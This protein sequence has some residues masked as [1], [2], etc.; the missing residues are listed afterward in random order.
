MKN[1]KLV[2]III[3]FSAIFLFIAVGIRFFVVNKS[4]KNIPQ[5]DI[6]TQQANTTNGEVDGQKAL[7]LLPRE[8][9][10]FDVQKNG[11]SQDKSFY[12]VNVYIS[13]DAQSKLKE[14]G[15]SEKDW[16]NYTGCW[17]VNLRNG[18]AYR[19]ATAGYQ[20]SNFYQWVGNDEIELI[21]DGKLTA[22]TYNALSK[23]VVSTRKFNLDVSADTSNWKTYRSEEFGFEMK[24]PSKLTVKENRENIAENMTNRYVSFYDSDT[25]ATIHLGLKQDSE[26][27]ISPRLYRTGIPGGEFFSRGTVAFSNGLAREVWFINC[28]FPRENHCAVE[29]VWFCNAKGEFEGGQC[30]NIDLGGKEAFMEVDL[31]KKS[32]VNVVYELMHGIIRTFRAF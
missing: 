32:N 20:D 25:G 26:K 15:L 28:N 13:L 19:I 1:I 6:N 16:S 2:K 27:N 22:T 3:V 14:A 23:D 7:S 5:S 9:L 21:G 4:V 29:F 11:F 18:K 12:S 10:L 30:D 24:Y 8:V 17:I 31:A